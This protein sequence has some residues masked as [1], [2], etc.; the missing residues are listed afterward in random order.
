MLFDILISETAHPPA[1]SAGRPRIKFLGLAPAE[2]TTELTETKEVASS[3]K[4]QSR[5]LKYDTGVCNWCIGRRYQTHAKPWL[6][7]FL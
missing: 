4:L 7:L 5:V 3:L 2:E 6:P 1:H